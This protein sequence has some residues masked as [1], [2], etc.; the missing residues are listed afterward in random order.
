MPTWQNHLGS[1]GPPGPLMAPATRNVGG[2]AKMCRYRG[3][4]S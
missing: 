2:G 4:R 3:S 1:A